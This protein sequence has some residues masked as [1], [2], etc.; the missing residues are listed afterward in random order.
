MIKE[1]KIKLNG[2]DIPNVREI[3]VK[4]ETPFDKRGIYREPTFAA[5]VTII[6]D[7][8]FNPIVDLFDMATNEDGRKNIIKSGTLE[9]HGDDVQDQYSFEITKAFITNWNLHN[10]S[11]PNSPSLEKIELKVGAIEFK[12]GGGGAKFD[13]ATFK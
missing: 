8:S 4:L 2:K 10:P 9:F 13:L 5:T 3:S 11:S 6:R 7:A 1:Q 12:A